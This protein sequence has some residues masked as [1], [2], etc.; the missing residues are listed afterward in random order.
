MTPVPPRS[1]TGPVTQVREASNPA[2]APR[3]AAAPGLLGEAL[4]VSQ[5]SLMA[6]QRHQEQ[7]ADL[8]RRFR[9]VVQQ[10]DQPGINRVNLFPQMLEFVLHGSP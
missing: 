6:L 9:P 10:P 2:A 5:E 8:H 1:P 4:R 3:R 7:L